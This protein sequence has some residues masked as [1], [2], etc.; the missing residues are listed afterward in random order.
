MN[1]EKKWI[2]QVETDIRNKL[3]DENKV[4]NKT[5]K[6]PISQIHMKTEKN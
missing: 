2:K 5:E 3:N 1:T 4:S 6:T